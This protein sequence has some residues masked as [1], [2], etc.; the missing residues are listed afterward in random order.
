M[1]F[2][3]LWG[4]DAGSLSYMIIKLFW[5]G[6]I[7]QD[8]I[9][10]L[11]QIRLGLKN[12]Y[13]SIQNDLHLNDPISILKIQ[14]LIF[15]YMPFPVDVSAELSPADQYRM[16]E[17]ITFIQFRQRTERVRLPLLAQKRIV[18]FLTSHSI[19]AL[20]RVCRVALY[21]ADWCSVLV[22]LNKKNINVTALG[23]ILNVNINI[24]NN[25]SG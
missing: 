11:Y 9:L 19:L 15:Q 13:F 2:S 17:Y 4:L 25:A 12:I 22:M 1:N 18:L 7:K 21:C 8:V 20:C 6:E 10:K 16:F 23:S 24:F 14:R 5:N 3:S